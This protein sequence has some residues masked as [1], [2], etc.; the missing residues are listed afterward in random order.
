MA[1][2]KH[3]GT[4]PADR[5]RSARARCR[6]PVK[7][8]LG[9]RTMRGLVRNLSEEGL[10][11]VL[12]EAVRPQQG[13]PLNFVLAKPGAAREAVSAL[14]WHA[15]GYCNPN[16]GDGATRLGLVIANPSPIFDALVKRFGRVPVEPRP[17][18]P[19]GDDPSFE[20]RVRGAHGSHVYSFAVRAAS[21]AEARAK[22]GGGMWSIVEVEEAAAASA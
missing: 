5:R 8:S 6:I 4:A 12:N 11:I 20:V 17:E 7:L 16:N 9:G 22:F 15:R 10:C 19:V 13:D 21:E 2:S 18:V 14:V 3:D 1:S